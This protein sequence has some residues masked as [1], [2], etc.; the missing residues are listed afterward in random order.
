MGSNGDIPY[1]NHSVQG[2]FFT[3]SSKTRQ[4]ENKLDILAPAIYPLSREGR[5][6]VNR[7]VLHLCEFY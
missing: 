3:A 5:I 1:L 4:L 6:K 2:Y 7:V